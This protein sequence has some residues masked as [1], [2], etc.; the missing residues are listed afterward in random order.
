[1]SSFMW[2]KQ[3]T[4]DETFI[5]HVIRKSRVQKHHQENK[6]KFYCVIYSEES[7]SHFFLTEVL[8]PQ[9]IFS[10]YFIKYNIVQ[11]INF[12]RCDQTDK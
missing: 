9:S 3:L 7:D 6:M 2:C 10:R 12:F 1:M 11:V 8:F 4:N 5:C